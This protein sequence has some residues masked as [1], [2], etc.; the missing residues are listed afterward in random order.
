[1]LCASPVF[2]WQVMA[3][4]ALIA[5]PLRAALAFVN[6]I[7]P[8]AI[9]VWRVVAHQARG[10]LTH[11]ECAE[12]GVLERLE[13]HRRIGVRDALAEDA[14]YAAIDI[15]H[16]QPRRPEIVR[17]VAEQ[18][19]DLFSPTGVAGISAYPVAVFQGLKDRLVRG[20]CGN[21]DV[22]AALGE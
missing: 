12:R 7:V 4:A 9:G 13:R 16:H 2:A 15:V 19:I 17:H 18:Q 14:R 8:R 3:K 22:H 6:M 5:K 11:Q 21:G 10:A 20:P 1:M